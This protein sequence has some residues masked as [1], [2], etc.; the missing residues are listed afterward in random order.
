MKSL[1]LS[2][3]VLFARAAAQSPLPGTAPLTITGDL[4]AQMVDDINTY[5]LRES[6]A[7]SAGRARFWHRDFSSAEAYSR[8]VE[9]NRGHLARI[10]GAVDPPLQVKAIEFE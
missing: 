3:L 10:I 4:A 1:Y 9:P 5:L 8:S 6:A 7:A 2:A